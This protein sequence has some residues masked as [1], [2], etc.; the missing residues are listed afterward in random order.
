[1]SATLIDHIWTNQ[2]TT[3]YHAGIIIN[4]LSDHF[5]VFYI[6]E[7]KQPKNPIPNKLTRRINQCRIPV[8]CNILKS[9]KWI[10]V[11]NETNPKLAF[12]HFFNVINNARDEAF[13]E[14]KVKQKPQKFSHSPWIT[15]G[16]GNS[17]VFR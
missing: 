8:F 2:I 7:C 10:N 5:P 6:E 12:D 14:I 11:T 16:F 9:T 4:S 13:P 1:M 17:Q 15:K 3:A